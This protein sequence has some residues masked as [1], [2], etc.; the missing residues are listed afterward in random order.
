MTQAWT[1]SFAL[2]DA[3]SLQF[4]RLSGDFNPLHVDPIFARRTQFGAAVAHGIHLVLKAL[5][6]A[7]GVGLVEPDRIQSLSVTFSNPVRAGTSV[8]VRLQRDV[9]SQRIR[10]TAES[11]GLAAFSAH[12]DHGEQPSSEAHDLVSA[13]FQPAQPKVLDFPHGVVE[14]DRGSLPLGTDPELMRS[15]FPHLRAQGGSRLVGALC[16]TT[17]IVGMQCPGLHSIFA[18]LKLHRA[19]A[20]HRGESMEF[21]VQ[22]VDPRFR[23]V[24]LS[25]EGAGYEGTLETFFRP[26]PVLQKSLA[27]VIALTPQRDFANQTAL[28]VGGSRGLGELTAKILLAGGARVTVTYSMGKEEAQRICHEARL[29]DRYC[30]SL[31]LDVVK[32]LDEAT[33]RVLREGA[34]THLYYFASPR[35]QKG[36][37]EGWDHRLFDLFA[38]YYLRG[39]AEVSQQMAGSSGEGHRGPH[40]FIPSTVFID[41]CEPGF[42]E[43]CAAKVAAEALCGQ[44][45]R[46]YASTFAAPRLPRMRTDQTVGLTDGGGGDALP[47]LDQAVMR[48]GAHHRR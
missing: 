28:V 15:S 37:A 13:P 22:R 42:A 16:A 12:V 11:A 24:L 46:R 27:E 45:A 6:W 35:I 10:I 31:A 21:R 44:L 19:G 5:D 9:L 48:F 3:D 34:F 25:V 36:P 18:G 39:M 29:H 4:A 20:S 7:A 32:P 26:P 8:S 14:G 2:S 41:T 43:Y 38:T 1:E 17:R 40:L 47:I 23:R 33:S 30:D